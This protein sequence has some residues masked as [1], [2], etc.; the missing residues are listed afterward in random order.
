MSRIHY[1]IHLWQHLLK[2]A[3]DADARRRR[4]LAMTESERTPAEVVCGAGHVPGNGA[5]KV[6]AAG[7]A[8]VLVR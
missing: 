4:E 5:G 3:D 8:P 7:D 2:G 1:V 6:S